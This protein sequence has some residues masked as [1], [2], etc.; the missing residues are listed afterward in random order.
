MAEVKTSS[1]GRRYVDI[2]EVI[3]RRLANDKEKPPEQEEWPPNRVWLPTGTAELAAVSPEL[4]NVK[5]DWWARESS[6]AVPDRANP[7]AERVAELEQ[8]MREVLSGFPPK[9]MIDELDDDL[10]SG[11]R[12]WPMKAPTMATVRRWHEL[13]EPEGTKGWPLSML[14]FRRG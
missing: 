13:L 12:P 7:L 2:D 3:Q 8:A 5:G 14:R 11:R 10:R 9:E 1:S 6:V 4:K